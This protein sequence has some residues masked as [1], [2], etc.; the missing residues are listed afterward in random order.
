MRQ[1]IFIFVSLLNINKLHFG[2][3][4]TYPIDFEN[5]PVITST[6]GGIFLP[7]TALV[8]VVAPGLST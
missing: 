8:S 2:S 1:A 4:R 6:T 3:K 7:N 5:T